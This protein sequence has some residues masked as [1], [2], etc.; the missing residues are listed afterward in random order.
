MKNLGSEKIFKNWQHMIET[1][2]KILRI[3][4][5]PEGGTNTSLLWPYRLHF[6]KDLSNG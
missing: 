3:L 4:M 6:S 2:N 5:Y 1:K